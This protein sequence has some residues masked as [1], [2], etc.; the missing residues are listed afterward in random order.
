MMRTQ[1]SLDSKMYDEA[2][3]QAR[4]LGISF[5]EFCRR[6]VSQALAVR[7]GERP[8]LRFSGALESGDPEASLS[9]DA[10]VY[11]RPEP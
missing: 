1:I 4:K 9:V 7:G 6:A 10:I 3:R 11:D 8:W 5:A 2:R